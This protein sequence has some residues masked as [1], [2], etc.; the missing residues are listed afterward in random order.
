VAPG[1]FFLG[2][3]RVYIVVENAVFVRTVSVVAGGAVT[4]GHL[5]IHMSPFKESAIGFVALG[6][7]RGYFFSQ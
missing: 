2:H 6:T 7:Q 3:G 4:V 1:A 5:I